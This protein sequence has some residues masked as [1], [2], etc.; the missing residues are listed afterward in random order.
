MAAVI[1]GYGGASEATDEIERVGVVVRSRESRAPG[2]G[3]S[4]VENSSTMVR[5]TDTVDFDRR[6][7]NRS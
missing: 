7:R 2:G 6:L 5:T 1:S 4:L 3:S